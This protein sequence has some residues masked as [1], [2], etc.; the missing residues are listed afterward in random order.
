MVFRALWILSWMNI[1]LGNDNMG[2]LLN[3]MTMSMVVHRSVA[4]ITLYSTLISIYGGHP[5]AATVDM[6]KISCP[7]HCSTL[8]R[9]QTPRGQYDCDKRAVCRMTVF[10]NAATVMSDGIIQLLS[11]IVDSSRELAGSLCFIGPSDGWRCS[12]SRCA[13]RDLKNVFYLK[14]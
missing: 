13:L 3:H 5:Q 1:G 8:R 7:V 11:T 2:C 12:S 4:A 9:V 10:N 14:Y 6:H